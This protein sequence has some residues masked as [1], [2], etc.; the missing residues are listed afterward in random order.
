M[1]YP[2]WA[3]DAVLLGR[4][5]EEYLQA[6]DDSEV[7]FLDFLWSRL[8]PFYPPINFRLRSELIEGADIPRDIAWEKAEVPRDIAWWAAAGTESRLG[9]APSFPNSWFFGPAEADIAI[10]VT[11]HQPVRHLLDEVAEL[12]A[13]FAARNPADD[14]LFNLAS[15][16]PWGQVQQRGWVF[17]FN[18]SRRARSSADDPDQIEMLLERLVARSDND[19]TLF[20]R[21]GRA[22]GLVLAHCHRYERTF[23]KELYLSSLVDE[24]VDPDD[25]NRAQYSRAVQANERRERRNNEDHDGFVALSADSWRSYLDASL[26]ELLENPLLESSSNA[27]TWLEIERGK[28]GEDHDPGD[29][30][31]EF[32][33]LTTIRAAV[34]LAFGEI[35]HTAQCNENGRPGH[36]RP[37]IPRMLK[38]A[39]LNEK[40]S[41]DEIRNQLFEEA[42]DARNVYLSPKQMVVSLVFGVEALAKRLWSD[43]FARAGP[44]ADVGSVLSER[45]RCGD[46]RE[47]RFASLAM[48][49]YKTYR[50]RADH[51]FD[52]FQCTW[53]GAM[54]CFTGVRQLLEWSE[55]MGRHAG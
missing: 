55:E 25:G 38:I 24:R 10:R 34:W 54:L 13:P 35:L 3:S 14:A 30:P 27:G 51:D 53:Q 31:T 23:I 2:I 28:L 47:K 11:R 37:R 21:A 7:Y 46:D 5:L 50:N 32:R 12:V 52:D 44:K 18:R 45:L 17:R 48:M 20:F 36:H 33:T 1:P 26:Q 22:L 15:E 6:N 19:C 9:F 39:P 41:N 8:S 4:A 43:E 42:F 29:L 49:L 40:S 16:A